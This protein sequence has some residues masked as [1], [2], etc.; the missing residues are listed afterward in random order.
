VSLLLALTLTLAAPPAGAQ[1]PSGYD[2]LSAGAV[3]ESLAVL[4]RLDSALKRAPRDPQLWLR[5]GM[6]AWLLADRDR[7]GEGQIKGIDWTLLRRMAD[8]SL[9]IAVQLAPRDPKVTM[10]LGQLHIASG[11]ITTR[12]Q[13]YGLFRTSLE[14]ARKTGDPA[15]A[16]EAAIEVGRIHWRRYEPVSYKPYMSEDLFGVRALAENLAQDTLS[17]AARA[18]DPDTARG[19]IQY[20]RQSIRAARDSITRLNQRPG[21]SFSGEADYLTAEGYFAEAYAA[22]P[23]S[24]RAFRHLAMLYAERQRW[25][26]LRTLAR[27]RIVDEPRHAWA[28]MSLGLA[29]HRLGDDREAVAAFDSAMLVMEPAERTRLDRFERL[30]RPEDGER[31]RALADS[32]RGVAEGVYWRAVDQLWSR[33]EEEPRTEFLARV[34]YADL[35][36]TVDEMLARGAD[37]DRGDIHIR[38]GPPDVIVTDENITSWGYDYAQLQFTFVGLPTFGTSYH[39]SPWTVAQVTDSM[40]ARWDNISSLR[41]DSIPTGLTRFRWRGDTAD[42]VLAAWPDVARIGA[43]ADVVA[44]VRSL[45]WLMR[46]DLTPLWQDSVLAPREGN[47]SWRQ[48]LAAGEY[49]FRAEA[50]A[51]ASRVAG[52]TMIPLRVG[53]ERDGFRFSGFGMSDLLFTRGATAVADAERWDGLGAVAVAPRAIDGRFGLVWEGYEFGEAAGEARYEVRLAVR[54]VRRGLRALV[55]S[56][57]A[58]LGGLVGVQR[59]EDRVEVRFE[60][61]R[62]HRDVLVDQVELNLAGNPAGLYELTLELRDRVSGRRTE[63]SLRFSIEG[64]AVR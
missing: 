3:A 39:M 6:V 47:R 45:A 10:A 31:V 64:A 61:R 18:W 16:S 41:I 50:S 17:A 24:L 1:R 33:R 43:A 11:L 57:A 46:P 58:P 19:R 9:R 14:E 29:S 23:R 20:T 36:W 2:T 28:W 63:R 55:A 7:Y 59:R 60:R 32:G 35:R 40:P 21:S 42:V 26:E 13:S 52:R 34:A 38:Y 8:T 51:E 25:T 4:R 22:T 30:L 5:R 15:L 62:A 37:T 12:V 53:E 49:L 56:A 48:R 27:E 44:P 54:P